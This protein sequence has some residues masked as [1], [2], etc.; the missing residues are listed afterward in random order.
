MLHAEYCE[1]CKRD[2]TFACATTKFNEGYRAHTISKNITR[3]Y[4][5]KAAQR[6]EVDWAG[7]VFRPILATGEQLKVYFFVGVLPYS[8]YAYVEPTLD[9][10]ERTWLRCNVHMLE[11]F[12]GVPVRITC[13]NL[14]TGVLSHPREGDIVLNDAYES[15]GAYY[16]LAIMPAQVRK[17]KQKASAEGTVRDITT[18]IIAK[19]RNMDFLGFEDVR[20]TTKRLLDEYNAMPFQKR[21]GSRRSVFEEVEIHELR[22]LPPVRYD[23]CEWVYNRS[24]NLNSHVVFRKCHYSAPYRYV[25]HKVDLRVGESTIEIYHTHERIATHKLFP[26]FVANK[27]STQTDHMPEEFSRPEWDDVRISNWSK[28]IG[29][30]CAD[31]VDR[32]FS[33]VQIKEQAYNPALSVLRLSKRYGADRLED[34]CRLTLS[35]LRSPRYRQLKSLLDSNDDKLESEQGEATNE[36]ES[37]GGGHV[38]GADYYR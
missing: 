30:N 14:K 24:V 20:L 10:K 21:E 4:T 11:H 3:N 37:A 36:H 18:F 32:I 6:A 23:I 34:A 16:A 31:V 33:S 29:V 9:M 25:G 19:M 17:P 26:E 7:A 15:L 1:Q 22:A 12:G 2:K 38:R 27:Y 13:D 5:H 28:Q 8:Q 35:R